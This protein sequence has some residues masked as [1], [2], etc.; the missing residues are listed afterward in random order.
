MLGLYLPVERVGQPNDHGEESCDVNGI[1]ERILSYT[2]SEHGLGIVR[3]E[4]LWLQR[5]L[6]QKPKC[7]AQRI[8]DR[9]C[10]P[11]TSDRLPNLL[12]ERVRRD[13]AV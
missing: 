4:L 7:R 6:L 5:E 9:R 2:G 10:A 3:T 12:A 13:R 8:A 11:V 1:D